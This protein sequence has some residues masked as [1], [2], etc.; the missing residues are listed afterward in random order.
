M[1]KEKS[2]VTL[3]ATFKC[4]IALSLFLNRNPISC[5]TFSVEKLIFSVLQ[6][7]RTLVTLKNINLS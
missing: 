6:S 3:I 2:V 7:E 1:L 5:I 4:P